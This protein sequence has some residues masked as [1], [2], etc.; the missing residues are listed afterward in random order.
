MERLRCV[1]PPY[2]AEVTTTLE[3]VSLPGMDPLTLFR[4]LANNP[5]VFRR[6]QRAGLLDPGSISVRLRELAIL[7]TCALCGAEYEWGVHVKLF[8]AAAGLD[9][10]AANRTWSE[11][12]NGAEWTVQERLVLRLCEALHATNTL[13]DELWR[14]LATSF[15]T[16]QLLELIAL[17][18]FYHTISYMVNGCRVPLEP[19]AARAPE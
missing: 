6:I 13:D 16:A 11:G 14:E 15:E 18:G 7:R 8:G 3:K 10:A 17:A 5:R 9:D 19:W 12:S 4:I 1:Q 2:S